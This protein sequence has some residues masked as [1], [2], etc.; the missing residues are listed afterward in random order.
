[1]PVLDLPALRQ[2]IAARRL[3]PLHLFAGTDVRLIE[4][5][6]DAVEATIDEADRPFAID[7]LYAGEAGASPVDIVA[8]AQVL[9]MLGDRRLVIVLR[10]ERLL[11][12]KRAGKTAEAEASDGVEDA[13][14]SG[15]DLTPLEDYVAQPASFTTLLFVASDVDRTRRFTK[16]LMEKAQVTRFDGLGVGS[17]ADRAGVR[18]EIAAQLRGELSQ[19]GRAIDRDALEMLIDRAGGEISKLR[20]DVERL[21]L[22]TQGQAKISRADVAEVTAIERELDDWAVTN[23]LA[24][25]DAATALREVGERLDRGDSPHMLMGQLR[26]W[27]SNR[28]VERAPDRVR[29]ALDALLRTDLALKSSGGEERVL[30][31]RLVVELT[32]RR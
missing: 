18:R 3:A 8:S 2:H 15:L 24:A 29:P 12:P 6:V 9:P 16:R 27:V 5:L 23:A 10:A 17:P 26:W 31:E 30:I 28:L 11:K 20:G 4:Q 32:A 22:Y 13:E 19:A 1:V 7:R 25:G 14:E 21:L